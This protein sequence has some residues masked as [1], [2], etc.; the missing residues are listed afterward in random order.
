MTKYHVPRIG[1]VNKMDRVGANLF[2]AVESM[3]DRLGANAHPIYHSDWRG[4]ELYWID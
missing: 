2:A 1:F 3:R 4:R